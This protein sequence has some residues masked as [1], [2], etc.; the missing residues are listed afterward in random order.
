M[1]AREAHP[2]AD[3][4]PMMDGPSYELL[5]ADIGEHG[6]R[7]P[8]LVDQQG[9]ILDG[10]NRHQ[11][12]VEL[13][14]APKVKVYEGSEDNVLALV[15]SLNLHRRHLDAGQRAMVAARLATLRDGQRAGAGIQA[16]VAVTQAQAAKVMKVSRDSV[17]KARVVQQADP[18]VAK[19]V[20]AGEVSLNKA[21]KAV[22]STTSAPAVLCDTDMSVK[23]C[24]DLR[25]MGATKSEAAAIVAVL[26]G[27]DVNKV[28]MA[29]R[30]I[31]VRYQRSR[32]TRQG[33]QRVAQ[34]LRMALSKLRVGDLRDLS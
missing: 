1:T 3:L 15:V 13:G 23:Y 26:Q 27:N 19:A 4:F 18:E 22:S 21:H 5:K 32:P 7:E 9:R 2:A 6:Q 10:R 29:C 12:C 11:A 25:A 8:V 30:A 31:L 24:A 17:Q 14:L 20:E 34:Q 16:P 33:L 28:V